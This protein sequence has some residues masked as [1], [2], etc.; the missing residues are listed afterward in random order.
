[1]GF[2]FV[3]WQRELA[4]PLIDLRLF[5]IPAFSASLAT[6]T[7]GILV[8]AGTFLFVTQYLQLVLG[9][10]PLQAGLWTLPSGGGLIAGSMLGPLIA[11]RVRPAK[12]SARGLA[13]AVVGL[14]LL[15][16]VGGTSGLAVLVAGSVVLNLG[17]A[18][19]VPLTTDIMSGA[20]RPS[21][22]G[23]LPGS[24]RPAPS[25]A[26]HSGSRCSEASARRSNA[27]GWLT[28]FRPASR[29]VRRRLRATLW[30]VL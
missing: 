3:R 27:P 26:G 17:I 8:I 9:F 15:T 23:R 18:A 30:A 1:M 11:L 6:N 14:C 2:A 25:S 24:R 4:D 22:P 21:G 13:L 10:T 7:L 12:A 5:R 16:Q 28:P 19:V 20:S 29:P